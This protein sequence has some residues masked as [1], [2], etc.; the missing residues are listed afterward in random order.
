MEPSPST[1]WTRR[2][3]GWGGAPWEYAHDAISAG[4]DATTRPGH[5]VLTGAEVRRKI[6]AACKG[7]TEPVAA[8]WRLVGASPCL[9]W[10]HTDAVRHQLTDMRFAMDNMAEEG[11]TRLSGPSPKAEPPPLFVAAAASSG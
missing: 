2:R 3:T 7:M 1:G 10:H 11:A 9:D 8:R 5:H 4:L 6:I